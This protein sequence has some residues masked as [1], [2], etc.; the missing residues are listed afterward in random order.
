MSSTDKKRNVGIFAHVDA[1]K[2]TTTEQML[3]LSGHIQQLG[4]VNTGTTQ[5]DSL[6][7]ERQ[8]GISVRSAV[9]QF[10][11]KD[12]IF[13][14]IDTPGHI[15]FIS[16]VE[17]TLRVM[18]GAILIVSA[19]EGVQAQTEMVWQALR[20]LNLPTLLFVNKLDRIGANLDKVVESINKSLSNK[21]IPIQQSLGLE[22]TFTDVINVIDEEDSSTKIELMEVIAE[23]DESLLVEYLDTGNLLKS[24]MEEALERMVHDSDLFPILFGASKLGIGIPELMDA[25]VR[26]LPSPKGEINAPLSGLVFKLDRD[27]LM[28]RMAYVRLYDGTMQ[29][30]D[31]VMNHTRGIQEKVT[32]IRWVEGSKTKDLGV[33]K[34]GDLAVVYGFND[35][36]IGDIIGSPLSVPEALKQGLRGWEVTDLIVTLVEGEHH[37]YHTHPL[38]F[39]VA[40]PMGIMDG[41]QKTGTQLLEPLLKVR[42]SVPEEFGGK[43]MNEVIQMRG[44]FETPIIQD[45]RMELEGELPVSTS[46]DFPKRLASMTKGRG[47]L[48]RSFKGY[49]ECPPEVEAERKRVG[50]NPLD[51]SKWIL[52]ARQALS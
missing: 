28:G 52:A 34:A 31:L 6:D 50:V 37:V 38:D 1:G 20:S 30:R 24:D 13:Q 29:N 43:L 51:Q 26:Y 9:T 3:Y 33:M 35:V 18:D 45:G 16:E 2:T 44:T 7:V 8:R 22:E 27:P 12:T 5:T 14:L 21:A 49:K 17:R 46:L 36:R 32:Q 10:T 47:T 19:V 25:A 48:T 4:D 11:W 39:A 15:D 23:Q 41:L 42:L 40:T